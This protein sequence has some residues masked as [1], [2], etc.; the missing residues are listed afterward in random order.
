MKKRSANLL[1]RYWRA[2]LGDD[3][4][5]YRHLLEYIRRYASGCS[6][7]DIGCTWGVNGDYA[8]I[9]EEAAATT[10]K[11]VDVFGPTPE[12]EVKKQGTQFFRRI[13][14]WRRDSSKYDR[15]SSRC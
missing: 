8:F 1:W 9:A 14:S 4:G 12:F 13:H 15:E 3:V 7:V 11:A 6:F 10:V 5:D 2:W